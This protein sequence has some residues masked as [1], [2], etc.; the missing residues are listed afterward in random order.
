MDITAPIYTDAEKSTA[1][2]EYRAEQ[3][4]ALD[5]MARQREARL[6]AGQPVR[7][8]NRGG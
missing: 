4:A 6:S 2:D 7:M 3:Q 1:W 5:R 8:K